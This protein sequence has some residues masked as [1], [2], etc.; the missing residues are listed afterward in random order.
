MSK[1]KLVFG[2]CRTLLELSVKKINHRGISFDILILKSRSARIVINNSGRV[3]LRKKVRL[4]DNCEIRSSKSIQLGCGTQIGNGT[5]I[6]ST[7]TGTID[8]HDHVFLNRNCTVVSCDK[9]EIGEG[10]AIGYNVVILDHDHYFVKEGTQPWNDI[11][12]APVIIGKD[13]WIGAN[14]TILAGTTIGDNA[15]IAA[16]SVIKGNIPK[17]QL[18][19]QK[20]TTEFRDIK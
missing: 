16:G 9:I 5:A 2:V 12:T 17:S 8:I 15:V 11:K 6:I 13:V 18:V 3:I 10:T 1:L 7:K 19:I 4:D 14:V 20:R